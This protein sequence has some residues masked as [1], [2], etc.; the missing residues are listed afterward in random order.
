[1]LGSPLENVG[2]GLS[3]HRQSSPSPCHHSRQQHTPCRQRHRHGDPRHRQTPVVPRA[4]DSDDCR[5]RA[6]VGVREGKGGEDERDSED[7]LQRSEQPR[8]TIDDHANSVDLGGQQRRP[9]HRFGVVDGIAG[10]NLQVD[11]GAR[12]TFG[13][14]RN[15][16]KHRILGVT[17][18]HDR[19]PHNSDPTTSPVTLSLTRDTLWLM[20]DVSVRDLRNQGGRVLDRV[21]AGERFVVTR[22]GTPVAE[23]RPLPGRTIDAA[24]I[25]S[26]WQHLPPVDAIEFRAD[27]DAILDPEL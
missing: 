19:T 27:L 10:E 14:R 25:L 17:G 4:G 11:L 23:L 16:S 8:A 5:Q 26:R 1:V 13:Q 20:T 6:T 3:L 9:A 22:D 15:P 18:D 7:H 2:T 12:R 21:L 24:T